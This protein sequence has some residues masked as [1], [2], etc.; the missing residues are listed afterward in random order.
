M[1][2]P[3]APPEPAVY[4][5]SPTPV[6]P[7]HAP[8]PVRPGG[9]TFACVLSI[10]FGSL[11]ALGGL[12]LVAGGAAFAAAM[13]FI[14]VFGAVFAVLGVVFLAMGALGIAAGTMGLKGA[15]WARWTMVVLYGLGALQ[16]LLAFQAVFPLLIAAL[17]ITALV[18]LVNAPA[19]AWFNSRRPRTMT[20]M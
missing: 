12:I 17:Q 19:T 18:M 14:G 9:V 3:A 10:V 7:H 15:N 2:A 11:G 16:S 1:T 8:A 13:P 6:A 5:P 20:P 4:A